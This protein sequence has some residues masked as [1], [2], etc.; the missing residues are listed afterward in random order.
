MRYNGGAVDAAPPQHHRP[1]EST[2][3]DAIVSKQCFK[4][5][6]I[7]PLDQFYPHPR[8]ADGH[9]NK[10]KACAKRDATLH[11]EANIEKVRKYDRNRPNKDQRAQ[12]ALAKQK[13]YRH[14]HNAMCAVHRALRQGHISRQPCEQCGSMDVDAHHPDYDKPLEVMWLCRSHHRQ[15]H[16]DNGPGKNFR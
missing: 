9:L 6:V 5:C 16:A 8:M 12:S 13:K 10:C 15:W 11:R 7:L 4:C 3:S 14:A 1:R 2:M